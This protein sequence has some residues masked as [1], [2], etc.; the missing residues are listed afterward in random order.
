MTIEQASQQITKFW[1]SKNNFNGTFTVSEILFFLRRKDYDYIRK[2]GYDSY[3]DSV[4]NFQDTFRYIYSQIGLD[5][6][7]IKFFVGEKNNDNYIYL[8]FTESLS[9]NEIEIVKNNL[10]VSL[11][12]KDTNM[13]QLVVE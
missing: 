8:V 5:I 1:A 3:F 7:K 4:E 2:L 10:H 6:G 12:Q 11:N 9:E 13:Y